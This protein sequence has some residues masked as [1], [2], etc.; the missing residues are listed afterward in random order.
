MYMIIDGVF[1][2][3]KKQVDEYK[4]LLRPLIH[5]DRRTGGSDGRW[6]G[7]GGR[8]G[9]G[10]NAHSLVIVGGEMPAI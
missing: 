6:E 5:Y 4:Q 1:R 8:R 7:G 2:S 3:D 9:G 10:F